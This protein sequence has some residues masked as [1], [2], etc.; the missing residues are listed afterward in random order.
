MSFVLRFEQLQVGAN[1]IPRMRHVGQQ[2]AD[3]GD[4][5][6]LIVRTHLLQLAEVIRAGV[7]FAA[8]TVPHVN[9]RKRISFSST[10]CSDMPL[11]GS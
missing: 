9:E 7:I 2:E 3:T 1:Q 4:D 8:A 11:E 6:V 10:A 5:I